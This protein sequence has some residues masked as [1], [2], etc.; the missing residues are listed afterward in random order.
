MQI[1]R[2]KIAAISN[3]VEEIQ[4][5]DKM[6]VV[7]AA[8]GDQLSTEAMQEGEVF[9]LMAM[10]SICRHVSVG[11]SLRILYMQSLSHISHVGKTYVHSSYSEGN[12]DTLSVVK[13][14]FW[15]RQPRG[16]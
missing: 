5:E 13:I 1:L 2:E 8:D 12:G 6:V 3:K 14:D 7:A 15:L 4:S 10:V 11:A 9:N 16:Y